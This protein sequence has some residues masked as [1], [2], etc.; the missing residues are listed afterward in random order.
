MFP[1]FFNSSIMY[2]CVSKGMYIRLYIP[3]SSSV[4]LFIFGGVL[5][6]HKYEISLTFSF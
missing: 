3:N 2:T 5:D 6:W 4:W 1:V